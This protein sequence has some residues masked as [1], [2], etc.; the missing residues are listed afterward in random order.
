MTIIRFVSGLRF[1]I[2]R[3]IITSFYG[4]DFVEDAFDFA[5]KIDLT[6]KGIVSAK[7]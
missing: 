3:V 2:R 6:F 7:A 4:M 5:F 1:D